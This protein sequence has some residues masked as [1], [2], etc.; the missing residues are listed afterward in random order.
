MYKIEETQSYNYSMKFY[1]IN[2]SW[3]LYSAI[4]LIGDKTFDLTQ[5][6]KKSM[7]F[8]KK[9]TT[10]PMCINFFKR[11][12]RNDSVY[13]FDIQFIRFKKGATITEKIKLTV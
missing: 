12:C 13:V 7:S 10:K 8:Y 2:N 9:L 1:R 6:F 3:V 4:K 11:I 5:G